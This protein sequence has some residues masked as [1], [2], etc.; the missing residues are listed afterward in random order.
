MIFRYLSRIKKLGKNK[1][2]SSY[3]ANQV[4]DIEGVFNRPVRHFSHYAIMSIFAL[5]LVLGV[6]A[7]SGALKEKKENPFLFEKVRDE[8]NE[9]TYIQS[10][11]TIASVI[12][13]DV[14]KGA[15]EVANKKEIAPTLAMAG[16][17]FIAK[18][19]LSANRQSAN[20]PENDIQTYIVQEGDTLW[21][22]ARKFDLTTNTLRWANNIRDENSIKPGKKLL[23]PPTVG[24]LYLV[25]EG[26]TLKGIAKRFHASV[27]MIISQNDLYGEDLKAGMKIMIPD[28]VGPEAPKPRPEPSAP[29]APQYASIYRPTSGYNNFPYGYCTWYVASR[30]NVAWSGDAWQWYG[31]AVAAGYAVGSQPVPGSIMVTWESGWGHVA[32]VESVNGNSFT[33]SEMNVNG[34]GITSSRTVTT[35]S[36][37]LIGFVY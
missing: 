16:S 31:N 19:V 29:A 17:G 14:A 8:V 20:K 5:V 22:I 34:W 11:A 26:D 13:K 23:I 32:Y 25:K 30:R 18:T 35:S 27:A 4:P 9:V 15:Y 2:S 1:V 12:D 21:T 6:F 24:V 33:V 28:G 3:V 37:P 7:G 10:V 36:V